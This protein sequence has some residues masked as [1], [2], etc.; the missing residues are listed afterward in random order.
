M[1]YQPTAGLTSTCPQTEVNL[2][3]SIVV[4]SMSTTTHYF[5]RPEKNIA[6]NLEVLNFPTM[7]L[8]HQSHRRKKMSPPPTIHPLLGISALLQWYRYNFKAVERK[9]LIKF[10]VKSS[11]SNL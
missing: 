4:V 9:D 10:R 7:L 6:R 3:T 5:S 2:P 8:W 1:A 11:P